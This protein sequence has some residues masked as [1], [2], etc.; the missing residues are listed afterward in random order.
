MSNSKLDTVAEDLFSIP[1]LLGRVIRRKFLKTALANMKRGITPPHI[2]ILRTL[3]ESGT[4]HVTEIG[5][6]LQIPGPQMTH[7][8]DK[9]VSLS[10]VDRQSDTNDRRTINIKLTTKG[11]TILKEHHALISD[12]FTTALSTLTSKELE[13]LSVSL[14]KLRD[15]LS[16]L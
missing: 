1:R 2:E 13:E 9:L 5:E 12:T 8:I 3:E 16:K 15:I 7:L 6:R 4:L 14:R 11:K 10:M